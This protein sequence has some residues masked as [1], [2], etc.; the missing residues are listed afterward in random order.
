MLS[1]LNV[2]VEEL[3]MIIKTI[4]VGSYENMSRQQLWNKFATLPASILTLVLNSILRHRPRPAPRL[5]IRFLFYPIPRPRPIR[6]QTFEP[7]P[8]DISEFEKMQMV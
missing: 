1:L 3:M 8:A 2:T 7:F 4:N 6:R 5:E